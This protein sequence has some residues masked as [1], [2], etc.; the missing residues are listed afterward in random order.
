VKPAIFYRIASVLLLLFAALH[1]FGFR[2]ADPKWGVDSLISLMQSMHFDAMGTS[3]TYWDFFVGF[4]L[5]FSVFL[6]FTAVL[7]WQLAG[8][9]SETLA[10]MRGT[11]WALVVC[12][13]A[14]TILSLRYA[15]I[16]PIAFSLSIL[17]CFT[18]AAWLST[19]A[20]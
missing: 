5:F 18:A 8:L 11:A 17:V 10:R 20:A 7:A 19:K 12:F 4:G 2:Q 1:T 16:L 9:P 13:A 15:F 3:R 14:V 6:V